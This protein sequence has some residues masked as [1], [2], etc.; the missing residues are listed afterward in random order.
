M[1]DGGKEIEAQP[2]GPTTAYQVKW[3][4]KVERDPVTWLKRAIEGERSN[5][6]KLID[7]EGATITS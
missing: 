6:E 1:R 5:I 2:G 3:T 4:S 7:E